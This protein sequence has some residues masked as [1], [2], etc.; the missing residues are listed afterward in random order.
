MFLKFPFVSFHGRN[1]HF[2][3]IIY[4][5]GKGTSCFL[6][7]TM[8]SIS[9]PGLGC[10]AQ[11]LCSLAGSFVSM[12]LIT[13]KPPLVRAHFLTLR[14]CICKN[15]DC[16]LSNTQTHAKLIQYIQQSCSD[17][18]QTTCYIMRKYSQTGTC[19]A[20]WMSHLRPPLRLDRMCSV[21]KPTISFNL[22]MKN[23]NRKMCKI[24]LSRDT[25]KGI[26]TDQQT[27]PINHGQL[28]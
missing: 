15:S 5:P 22:G 9:W 20:M 23:D 2:N 7:F 8:V 25:V 16:K 21:S 1:H 10:L 6:M 24:G 13:G 14:T 3:L 28:L 18:A 12:F 26:K 17:R 11:G 4:C 27:K 19:F